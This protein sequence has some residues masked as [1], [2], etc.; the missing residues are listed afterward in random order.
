MREAHSAFLRASGQVCPAL[1]WGEKAGKFVP[2][3]PPPPPS[4]IQPS[5]NL[6]GAWHLAGRSKSPSKGLDKRMCRGMVVGAASGIERTQ[7]G[8]ISGDYG[9]QGR[10]L[11]GGFRILKGGEDLEGKR[12]FPE[13]RGLCK[14]CRNGKGQGLHE[15][16]CHC[17]SRGSLGREEW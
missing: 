7:R 14:R 4:A 8:A 6:E 3:T 2:A 13:R 10:L 5:S 17:W 9:R 12:T 16:Q 15:R 1:C 11:G